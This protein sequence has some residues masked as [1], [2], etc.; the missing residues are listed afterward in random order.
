MARK[1]ISK[2][3]RFEVFKRDGF[4]CQYCGGVP[5]RVLLHVDHIV[6]VA[7]GGDNDMDNLIT[8]CDSCNIGKGAVSLDAVPQSL[9]D[10]T[11]E[12]EERESQ[13]RAYTSAMMARRDRLDDETWRVLYLMFPDYSNDG[14]RRDWFMS[15]KRF[16]ERLGFPE[17][18]SAAEYAIT[19][20][21]R[22]ADST[23]FR[24]FC[25]VC[26]GKIKQGPQ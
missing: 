20:K 9:Q 19:R 26:W 14:V 10:K 16:I 11:A 25:G 22:S 21:S 5:P 1:S 3:K 23:L 12:I 17:V 13:I 8:A 18:E 7:G 4:S 6:P 24:Y 2:R 15:T